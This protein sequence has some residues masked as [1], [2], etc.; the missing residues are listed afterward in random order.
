VAG[1]VALFVIR[2]SDAEHSF[3][4]NATELEKLERMLV[5]ES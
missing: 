4:I 3:G 1:L 5:S 2:D